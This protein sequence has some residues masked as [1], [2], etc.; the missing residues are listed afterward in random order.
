MKTPEILSKCEIFSKLAK[1]TP[2]RRQRRRSGVFIVKFRTD[3]THC[4]GVSIIDF[5]QVNAGFLETY[6]FGPQA[7]T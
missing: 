7:S 2:E 1:A 3:F 4:V 5:K 6:F